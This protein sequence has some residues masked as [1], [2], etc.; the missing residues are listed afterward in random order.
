MQQDPV[1]LGIVQT[2][3]KKIDLSRKSLQ[4]VRLQNLIVFD[5]QFCLRPFSVSACNV[6][7]GPISSLVPVCE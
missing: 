5:L 1:V 7:K 6:F 4:T 2:Q 3:N